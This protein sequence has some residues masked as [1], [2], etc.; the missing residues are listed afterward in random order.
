MARRVPLA[1]VP[2]GEELAAEAAA[3]EQ[4]WQTEALSEST[5]RT[6]DLDLAS[7]EDEL[8]RALEE[9]QQAQKEVDSTKKNI[10]KEVEFLSTWDSEMAREQER[11]ALSVKLS[12][13]LVEELAEL[14][15]GV[16]ARNA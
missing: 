6:S 16:Q 9:V 5:A 8:K 1:K 15:A 7:M 12:G 4:E 10:E 3:A 13:E 2:I 11:L 14:R